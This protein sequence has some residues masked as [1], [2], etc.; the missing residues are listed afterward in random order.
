[1]TPSD[2]CPAIELPSSS[3]CMRIDYVGHPDAFSS[4][5]NLCPT[6]LLRCIYSVRKYVL[7]RALSNFEDNTMFCTLRRSKDANKSYAI[8]MDDPPFARTKGRLSAIACV[9][10]RASKTRCTGEPEGCKRCTFRKRPCQYPNLRRSNTTQHGEQIEA[11]SS[12]FTM[13]DEQGSLGMEVSGQGSLD[14]QDINFANELTPVETAATMSDT[15]M[16][17]ECVTLNDSTITSST[18]PFSIDSDIDLWNDVTGMAGSDTTSLWDYNAG[19]ND[20]IAAISTKEYVCACFAQALKTYESAEV[21]LVWSGRAH[22]ADIMGLL[23]QQKNTISDC[24]RLLDCVQCIEKSAFVVLLISICGKVLRSV[25]D[26]SRELRPRDSVTEPTTKS[27]DPSQACLN[28]DANSISRHQLDDDDRLVVLGSL[29]LNRVT[30][31]RSLIAAIE[32]LVMKRN[33]HIQRDMVRQL[34]SRVRLIDT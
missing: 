20:N 25:E 27:K 12:T 14:A 24:E 21:H 19:S 6:N 31:L 11:S 22:T 7:V 28:I 18:I 15:M 13:S 9:D 23:Q 1:M 16:S 26:A 30:K 4:C 32:M 34:K 33:W 8:H 10:C 5:S 17:S 2:I 3:R 29:F